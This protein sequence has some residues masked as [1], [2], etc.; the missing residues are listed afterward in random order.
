MTEK[1]I[2]PELV[3]HRLAMK[4]LTLDHA[5]SVLRHFANDEI[6]RFSD[7]SN[8]ENPEDAAEIIEWGL[9]IFDRQTGAFMGEV[10]YTV[11]RDSNNFI[12]RVELGYDL[13]VQHWGKGFMTEAVSAAIPYIFSLENINRIE[14][15]IHPGNLRSQK[16]VERQG[17]TRE[18]V[19][20]E[21]AVKNGEYWDMMMYSLLKRKWQD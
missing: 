8:A 21:Y 1:K 14:A 11:R 10:N 6:N 12:H 7:S 17:F 19:L 20:R 13:G 9:H 18:A 4:K 2:F 15:V 5:D 16:V 3:T